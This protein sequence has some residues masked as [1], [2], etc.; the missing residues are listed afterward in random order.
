MY[1]TIVHLHSTKYQSHVRLLDK[2]WETGLSRS[3]RGFDWLQSHL[4]ANG[5]GSKHQH[6]LIIVRVADVTLGEV[7]VRLPLGVSRTFEPQ[8][9]SAYSCLVCTTQ[10]IIGT[11]SSSVI[12]CG[13]PRTGSEYCHTLGEVPLTCPVM[14]VRGVI[15]RNTTGSKINHH[16]SL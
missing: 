3:R 14:C 10:C 11:R 1:T 7:F 12:L 15:C 13:K 8:A 16:L 2:L 5:N 9:Q 6:C 4:H